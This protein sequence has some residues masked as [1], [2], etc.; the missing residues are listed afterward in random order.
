MLFFYFTLFSN[1]SI[2]YEVTKQFGIQ[3]L[4]ADLKSDD[5][6]RLAHRYIDRVPYFH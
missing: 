2:T 6:L 5:F 3:R 1:L 4:A